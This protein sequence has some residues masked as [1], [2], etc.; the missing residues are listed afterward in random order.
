MRYYATNRA[1]E[2]VAV[3]TRPVIIRVKMTFTLGMQ[4]S[5]LLRN[6]LDKSHLTSLRTSSFLT[7]SET[8][9]SSGGRH[10]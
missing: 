3:C 1:G 9:N 6:C 4:L 2:L 8:L 7:L 10:R 5:M